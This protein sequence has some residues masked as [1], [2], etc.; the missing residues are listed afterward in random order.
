M[1][2]VQ[3]EATNFFTD[4]IQSHTLALPIGG[5]DEVIANYMANGYV[6][7]AGPFTKPLPPHGALKQVFVVAKQAD[8]IQAIH[9]VGMDVFNNYFANLQ[10][11]Q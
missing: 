9:Q 11:G 1:N 6:F 4:F 7:I 3:G 8:I 5:D 10:L 2:V